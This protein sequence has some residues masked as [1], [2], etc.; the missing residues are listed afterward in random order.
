MIYNQI[1]DA[2]STAGIYFLSL[3]SENE[4]DNQNLYSKFNKIKEHFKCKGIQI[5]NDYS[6]YRLSE[7]CFDTG[8]I[9]VR[10]HPANDPNSK[11]YK[12]NSIS[13]LSINLFVEEFDDSYNQLLEILPLVNNFEPFGLFIFL[14]Q[15]FQIA[16]QKF[17]SS[18]FEGDKEFSV[19]KFD[20]YLW[21]AKNIEF[22]A[23]NSR[24]A[25]EILVPNP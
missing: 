24:L 2:I 3:R 25:P 21:L 1:N 10:Y 5:T 4:E 20:K 19:D 23:Y 7:E 11:D 8:S 6:P 15:T 14:S 17:I 16:S 12:K 9:L 22:D 18:M 13:Q